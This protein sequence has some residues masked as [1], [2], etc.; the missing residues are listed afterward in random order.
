M[1]GSDS[2]IRALRSSWWDWD[3]GSAPFYWRWPMWYRS[4]IRDG[5]A[6]P[7][8]RPPVKYMVP[9]RDVE[10]DRRKKLV[11]N[12][13]SKVL[14]RSYLGKGAVKSL[15]AFFDVPKG[16]NDIRMVYDGTV[17]GFND[18]I[19]VPKFGLPILR[20][21]LR[22]MD[23][24]HYMVDADVGECFLNFYLHSSLQPFVG[25]DLSKYISDGNK[26]NH[27]VRWHR[28]GMGLKSSP[29]QACQA[30]MVVEEVIK[31]NPRDESNP[32]RWDQVVCNLPGSEDYDPTKSWVYKI[33]TSDGKIACDIYI[34]MWTT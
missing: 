8:R 16:L 18:S 21:H 5:I 32:F 11:V 15:T 29:Y 12:K 33:R 17:N 30:M 2:L 19:E 25:V 14:G 9:Q 27:W 22:A 28:A 1:K 20:S 24:G 26:R 34:Y 23:P 13:L 7:F 4:F 6:F 31:G 10:D 3:D